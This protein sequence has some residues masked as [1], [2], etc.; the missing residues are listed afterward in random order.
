MTRSSV[1]QCHVSGTVCLM[2][3]SLQLPTSFQQ[4]LKTFIFQLSF[5]DSAFCLGMMSAILASL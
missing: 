1:M 2:M 4:L 3:L 5:L